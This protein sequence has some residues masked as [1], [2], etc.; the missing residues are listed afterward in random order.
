MSSSN[1]RCI[2]LYRL[3]GVGVVV[4]TA[5]GVTVDLGVDDESDDEAVQTEDL[6]GC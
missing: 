3:E 4:V 5:D 2:A 1:P 6:A